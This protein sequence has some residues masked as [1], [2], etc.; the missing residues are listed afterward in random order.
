LAA[1]RLGSLDSSHWMLIAPRL[2]LGVA[3]TRR[4]NSRDVSTPSITS[5][6]ARSMRAMAARAVAPQT[7]SFASIGS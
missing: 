2:E 3:I 6:S 7:M 1:T 4:W 5:S